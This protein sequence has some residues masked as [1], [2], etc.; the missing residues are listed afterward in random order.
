MERMMSEPKRVVADPTPIHPNF[1]YRM[2]D[3]QKFFGYKPTQ[4]NEL[5]ANGTIPT[6]LALS[7]GGRAR[8]WTGQQILDWQ[9]ERAEKAAAEQAERTAKADKQKQRKSA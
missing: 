3:G 7:E 6:P 1:I 2:I 4:I 9:A 5:I 8:G